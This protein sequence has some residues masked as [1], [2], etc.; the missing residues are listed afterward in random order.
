MLVHR[1]T[2]SIT[3]LPSF[4]CM[5]GCALIV[6]VL[7]YQNSNANGPTGSKLVILKTLLSQQFYEF[8]FHFGQF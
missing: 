2:I 3:G 6:A 4:F 7:V 8:L 5:V 1:R